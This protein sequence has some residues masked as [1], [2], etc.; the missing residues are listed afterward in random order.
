MTTSQIKIGQYV[1]TTPEYSL[2]VLKWGKVL[3][4]YDN[5]VIIADEESTLNLT[6]G[7]SDVMPLTD[8]EVDYMIKFNQIQKG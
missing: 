5:K 6:F 4:E 7:I 2:S 1:R 8:K 3:K